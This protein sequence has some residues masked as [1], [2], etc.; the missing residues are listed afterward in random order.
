MRAAGRDSWLIALANQPLNGA[1]PHAN[2]VSA[3]DE[4]KTAPHINQA[5]RDST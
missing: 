3:N 2:Q 5:R 4:K 1:L